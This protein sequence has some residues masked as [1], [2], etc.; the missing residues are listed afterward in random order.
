[1]PRVRGWTRLFNG[2][3]PD[4]NP[5]RRSVDRL[6]SLAVL[7]MV[8]VFLIATPLI[9]FGVG[10][11]A[12]DGG[13]ATA[14][15]ERAAWH[16]VS[17]VVL[18]G[19][20][21]PQNDPYGAVYLTTVPVRWITA[22]TAHTGRVTTAAGVKTGA[23]VSIWTKASGELTNAPLGRS[24]IAHQAFFAGLLAVLGFSLL[25]GVTSLAIRRILQRRRMAAWDAEW[26]A[27]GPLWSNYR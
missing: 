8:A 10:R 13:A 24:Q 7:A 26:R 4:H 14:Q 23:K 9:A 6:E 18:E 15:A 20:A 22:G 16:Q 3:R 17:A 21:R 19:A 25:L 5:L 27:T 11:W 2:L 1:M 12:W